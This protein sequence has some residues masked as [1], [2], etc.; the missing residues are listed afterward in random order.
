MPSQSGNPPPATRLPWPPPKADVRHAVTQALA[1]DI[2]LLGDLTSALLPQASLTEAQIVSRS[3]GVLA[4]AA[5]A[6]QTFGQVDSEVALNWRVSD[7]DRLF[8]GQTLAEVSGRLA[9][10][11]TAE[12]VALNFLSHLSGIATHTRSFVDAAAGKVAIFDTRKTTPGLRSLEKAAV[13]AGGGS[14]HRFGLS[15]WIMLKDN[16]LSAIEIPAAVNLARQRW[17]ARRVQ[18]ECD[19]VDQAQQ[20][21][22]SGADALL[23]DNMNPASV[24]QVVELRQQ[25]GLACYLEASGGITL[26]NLSQYL[27]LGLDA[28]SSGSLIGGAQALDIGLDLPQPGSG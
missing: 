25:R 28:I 11:C 5:C 21:I 2:G 13:R 8:A 24:K 20:A 12:R 14:S 18:V 9:S 10:V 23:L 16:H 7:G 15:D 19:S 17:P 27:N 3:S 1:E 22:D 26:E 4:G 6:T